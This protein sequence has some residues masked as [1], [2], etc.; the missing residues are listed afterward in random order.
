[1]RKPPLH[2]SF[3]HAFN[4]LF[5]LMRGERNFLIELGGLL[6]NLLFIGFFRPQPIEVALLIASALMVLVAEAL[7]T[8]IEKICDLVHPDF[9]RRVGKIKDMASGAVSLAVFAALIVAAL[10]YP[11]YIF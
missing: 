6:A 3:M 5:F 1:M 10:I 4:G 7:N 8:C 9:D 2:K 11:K